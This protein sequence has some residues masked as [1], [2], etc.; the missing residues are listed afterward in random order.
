MSGLNHSPSTPERDVWTEKAAVIRQLYLSERKTLKQVKEILEREH[1]FPIFPLSTYE[2]TL[3]DRL[4]LRK[5]LKRA[6]WPIVYHHF[7]NR[8]GKETGLYLNGARIPWNKAWKEIR[9]SGAR[10]IS[11]VGQPVPLPEGVTVRTP[12]PVIRPVSPP[13]FPGIQGS[14][15]S[16]FFPPAQT[17]LV[18]QDET[19][20]IDFQS[21]PHASAILPADQNLHDLSLV[22]Y[23][24]QAPNEGG[25]MTG[26]HN[27]DMSFYRSFLQTTPWNQF[28]KKIQSL[29]G[30]IAQPS[31][32]RGP[33]NG[34]L[35]DGDIMADFT[36]FLSGS[37]AY[38]VK[39]PDTTPLSRSRGKSGV[40][41]LNFSSYHFLTQFLHLLS[42]K[43]NILDS[44][45]MYGHISDFFDILFDRSHNGLLLKLFESGLPTM[46]A[47]W[48]ASVSLAFRVHHKRAFS[49]LMEVGIQHPDWILADGHIYLSLAVLMGCIG[50]VKCLLGI[51]ARADDSIQQ[52]GFFGIFLMPAILA[53]AVA[54]DLDC[55][56]QLI[57]GCDVHRI[58]IYSSDRTCVSNFD[59]FLSTMICRYTF[60]FDWLSTTGEPLG[61]VD[62][63]LEYG[64]NRQVLELFLE[65][66]ANVDLPWRGETH[67]ES[68]LFQLISLHDANDVP[69]NWKL[70]L[71]DLS[72][73]GDIMLY[74][75]LRVYSVK[76]RI[77]TTRLGICFSAK[78]GKKY[79]QAYLDSRPPQH[80]DDR[81]KLLELVLAE[82]FFK[83]DKRVIDLEIIRGLIDFGVDINL[84]HLKFGFHASHSSL[85]LRNLVA[86]SRSDGLTGDIS[87]LIASL[88][89][90]G[91]II[92]ADVLQAA[93]AKTGLGALP[94][95]A[96][97]GADIRA[98]GGLA[99]CTSARWNNF[100]AVMWLLQVGVDINAD[101]YR[102][103]WEMPRT[104][105]SVACEHGFD[106]FDPKEQDFGEETKWDSA[107]SEML[108]YLIN[109]G[110]KLRLNSQYPSHFHFLKAI[111]ATNSVD[112]LLFDKM[113]LFLNFVTV[114]ED[115]AITNET[116]LESCLVGILRDHRGQIIPFEENH[117]Q[118]LSVYELLLWRGCP[119][120]RD[121]GLAS[122]IYYGGRHDVIYKV[123]DA[124][125][126]VNAR[127]RKVAHRNWN[128]LHYPLQSAAARGDLELVKQLLER[129]ALINQPPLGFR[130]R[131]ALQGAC[132]WETLSTEERTRQIDLIKLLIS[133]GADV[134]APA[135]QDCGM[136]A[137]QIAALYGDIELALVLLEH[138]ANPNAPPASKN[139]FCALDAAA[140]QGRLDMVDLLLSVAAHSYHR[141]QSGYKGAIG[142]A[143]KNGHFAV[144]NLIREHIRLFGSCII[145]D[146][147][148]DRCPLLEVSE[149]D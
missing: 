51:G 139:G 123:L 130:G 79:L 7:R 141:G 90:R 21:H 52:I 146:L 77:E 114:P 5:K 107:N 32:L 48:E 38:H 13:A 99:L 75:R 60:R 106:W 93:V 6:D 115:L 96:E 68:N 42:N 128:G 91:A 24:S 12:S 140:R 25:T 118:R 78:R 111:L 112:F 61:W 17:L 73:Y 81:T 35:F 16:G 149:S 119:V 50:I 143:T 8:G 49:C 74:D 147:N 110:A 31:N 26:T 36:Y 76:E 101:I 66:G 56:K 23:A 95:L 116:L 103:N 70:T 89:G 58:I 133:Q 98:Q 41:A 4:Q 125:A 113:E 122:Y 10:S 37:L 102:M 121:S 144:A 117:H 34:R 64:I 22:Q 100:E 142:L 69:M 105:I 30:D 86:R 9:R 62:T 67:S 148:D 19:P 20:N 88:V 28:N 18:A 47:A 126:D 53:A 145:E 94:D 54:G 135:A 138:G 80:P 120:L 97:H 132:E 65:N 55:V 1:E 85:L 46:R 40:P 92:D 82:Q 127:P 137:L 43:M 84:P 33:T 14:L 108:G 57:Q 44:P 27:F 131:T 83:K 45:K 104:I 29:F 87:H 15:H 2:T 72:F 59:V 134:N 129:G 124:G 136:T 63:G 109:C 3:R 71:L 39:L 11:S